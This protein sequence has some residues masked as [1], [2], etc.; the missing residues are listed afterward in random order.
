M[1]WRPRFFEETIK[2][3]GRPELSEEGRKAIEGLQ[4][5]EWS[6]EESDV[7]GA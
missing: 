6:L 1:E 3:D 5:E 7:T 4:A 2:G